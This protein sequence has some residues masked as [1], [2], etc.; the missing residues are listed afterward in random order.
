MG[1]CLQRKVYRLLRATTFSL[2]KELGCR[3]ESFGIS[4]PQFHALYHIGGEGI[5]ANE[6]ARELHC[7]ASNMTG[8]VDRMVENGW[9]VREQSATDRRVWLIKLTFLGSELR[10][11]V[12][13]QYEKY[14][15]ERVGVLSPEELSLLHNLLMKLKDKA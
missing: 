13:P 5:Q 10:A 15:Q 14:V 11:K 8:L 3:V 7:N 12:L 6:L 1:D 4:W 9:V 2:K